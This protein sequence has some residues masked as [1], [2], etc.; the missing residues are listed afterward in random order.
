MSKEIERKIKEIIN[1]FNPD[2]LFNSSIDFFKSL[3]YPLD[4]IQEESNYTLDDFLDITGH[5]GETKLENY[6]IQNIEILFSLSEDEMSKKINNFFAGKIENTIIEA[7]LFLAVKL[8]KNVY[9]KTE[10][11]NI[12]KGIN[13]LLNSPAFI[14]FSYDDK[15]TLS[16]TDRRL[17]KNNEDK[18]V[19]EK[20]TL[21]K[22]IDR[23][24]VHRAHLDI[25]S[26]LE[27]ENLG[28]KQ[29]FSYFHN[30]LKKVLNTKELNKK[31][32]KEISNWY[33]WANETVKFPTDLVDKDGKQISQEKS[34]S[35]NTIRFITRMIFVWFLKEKN[36][37]KENIFDKDYIYENI[38]KEG[39]DKTG[40]T[41]Y[42]A[43]LQNLFFGTLNTEMNKDRD[44]NRTFINNQGSRTTKYGIHTFYRYKRFLQNQDES[45]VINLFKEI[46]FLN[47]GLFECLD[48]INKNEKIRVDM[49]SDNPKNEDKLVFP[50]ELLFGKEKDYD[51]N[52]VY[53]TSKKN[54]KVRG[55]FEILNDYKF[56]VEENTPLEEDVALDPELLGEIFENLLAS[57][58][59]E[60]ST[61]ARKQTG[62]FYTP[63]EI[64]NY[65]VDS[66]VKEYL[67]T[68][69]SFVTD[70][71]LN[72]LFSIDN[73]INDFD[74]NETRELVKALDKIK[75]LDPACGSGAFPMGILNRLVKLLEV[76]DPENNT[77]KVLRTGDVYTKYGTR[78]KD[79]EAEQK[80]L[81]MV[82]EIFSMDKYTAN[83]VRKLYIIENSIYGL[84]IQ[85]MAIQITKLR[86]FIS[87]VIEQNIDESKQNNG[88]LTLP[89]LDTKF[90]S[91]NSLIGLNIPEKVRSALKITNFEELRKE[92]YVIRHR[93][94]S[95]RSSTVK[96][97]L[98]DEDLK[99]REEIK[100]ELLRF[101]DE[102]LVDRITNWNPYKQNEVSEFFDFEFMFEEKDKFDI[103][104]GNPPYIRYQSLGTLKEYLKKYYKTFA[105]S[106]DIYIYFYELGFNL[107][108]ENG[109]LSYITSNKWT[110]AKYGQLFREF[111]LSESNI[112][113]YLD[114]NGFKVFESATV[115]TSVMELRKTKVKSQ[116][117]YC[118]IKSDYNS[119][120][121]LDNY[122]LDS[123]YKYNQSD[124]DSNNFTFINPIEIKIKNKIENIG[125][126]LKDWDTNIYVGIKSGCNPAFIVN[127]DIKDELINKNPNYVDLI[128]PILRGRDI[129]KYSY[130]FA[131]KWLLYIPWNFNLNE[132]KDIENYLLSFYDELNDRAG[133]K[134]GTYN[135]HVLHRYASG[136]FEDFLKE[137]IIYS[138]IVGSPRFTLDR[139]GF[140]PDYTTFIITG[141]SLR[142]ILSFL[143]SKLCTYIFKK[144]YSGGGLGNNYRYQ[145]EY[146]TKTPLINIT[147]VQENS[148]NSL[149]ELLLDT[150]ENLINSNYKF[151][152]FERIVDF[153]FYGL[154]FFKEMKNDESYINDEVEKI[155]GKYDFSNFEE[156]SVEVKETLIN[157]VYSEFNSNKL[158]L[159]ALTF[160]NVEEVRIIEESVQTSDSSVEELEGD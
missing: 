123:G 153:M 126:P 91:V 90:L 71:K 77:W 113:S 143:N 44:G 50:D 110:R 160:C 76:L 99:K 111:I 89:N 9:S 157:E 36:L 43:I 28:N 20:T 108:K 81:E 25:L 49:Y 3:N 107:L 60:T 122:V 94:F 109:V 106:A 58:N 83:Y 93:Y 85:P 62:S 150:K 61:T 51:L 35:E 142:Y 37:I 8:E 130:K 40:S 69:L 84:D 18:D 27:F 129:E 152:L 66:S 133:V 149:V 12:S 10:L 117:T 32:Y 120:K 116:F 34:N 68:N 124:L 72:L 55:L 158:I 121:N 127:N 29:N 100:Q 154:Y 54:Y 135:W 17:N 95:A 67:K 156:L 151:N 11:V 24:N 52:K 38:I 21:I 47:G 141:N 2:K 14:L 73:P 22:D 140:I 70:E 105:G 114:F 5:S 86:F 145:K 15:I 112:I 137:K 102:E 75:I 19:L 1:N 79:L 88:I 119:N 103:V 63:R 92:L 74:S 147:S 138:E 125:T 144:F 31:F 23:T 97:K 53:F 13:K 6:G 46:P 7:Y 48:K 155:L 104:I 132:H 42:K 146:L 131:E 96:N 118:S 82:E 16:V 78:K 45:L 26:K 80:A 56:T 30:E 65:M 59:E 101:L 87:L 128:K 159:K 39:A 98:I 64:V 115:D 139:K 57:Y 41:Y 136:Y 33:F 4:T 148:F 134:D